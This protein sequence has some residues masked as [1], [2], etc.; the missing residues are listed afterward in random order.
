MV[1]G[2]CKIAVVQTG[3]FTRIL[4]EELKLRLLL[5]VTCPGVDRNVKTTQLL[6]FV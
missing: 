3:Y 1:L 4:H 5:E 6:V 2:G